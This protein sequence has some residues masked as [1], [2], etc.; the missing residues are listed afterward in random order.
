MRTRLATLTLA[1][2][3]LTAGALPTLASPGPGGGG[4]SSHS[5]RVT[6]GRGRAAT[7]GPDGRTP[8]RVMTMAQPGLP[9]PQPSLRLRQPQLGPR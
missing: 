7:T 6:A 8:S 2:V 9:Q 5:G 3:L 1:V 4:G